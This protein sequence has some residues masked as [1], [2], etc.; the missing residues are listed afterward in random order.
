MNYGVAEA[1]IGEMPLR[2]MARERRGEIRRAI[3]P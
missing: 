1:G 3:E 2:D